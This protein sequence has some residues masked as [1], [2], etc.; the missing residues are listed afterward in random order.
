MGLT[1]EQVPDKI[2]DGTISPVI[3]SVVEYLPVAGEPLGSRNITLDG[4]KAL[5]R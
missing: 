5:Y 1:A 3:D 4:L 2:Y